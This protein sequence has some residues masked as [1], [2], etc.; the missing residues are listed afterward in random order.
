MKKSIAIADLN[1][2]QEA[3]VVWRGFEESIRKASAMGYDGV[4]LA[5]RDADEISAECLSAY[6]KKYNME[7]SA[8]T[9]G[10]IFAEKN[11]YMTAK[12]EKKK[13]RLIEEFFQ[14]IKC[15][16]GYTRKINVGRC[17]GYIET[18][19]TKEETEKRF[20][21]TMRV[22]CDFARDYHTQI[23]IEPVNRYECNFINT[24]SEAAEIIE[25]IGR[26]NC[27]IH[28]DLFHMNI[29]EASMEQSLIAHQEKIGYIHVADSNR[30]APG[31]GHINFRK[32][33]E[34]IQKIGYTDWVSVEILPGEN[35][36]E[37]ARKSI[38][39]LTDYC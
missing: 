39:F 20:I 32:I 30:Y 21:E 26:E 16:S 28:A 5:L 3:F 33:F 38:K 15:F 34:T 23:L 18:G 13:E 6:L 12:E 9:T 19:D 37:M 7:V 22:I 29:E 2:G 36:D 24:I 31:M 35:P 4:E 17:R 1:A 25:K 8:I 11:L 27:G 10:R 14:L